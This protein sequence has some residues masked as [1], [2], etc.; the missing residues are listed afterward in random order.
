MPDPAQDLGALLL[1]VG[2]LEGRVGEIAH[3]QNDMRMK[4]DGIAEKLFTAPTREDYDKLGGKMDE[5]LVR[6]DA[7]EAAKDREDGAKGLIARV[8]GSKAFG[9]VVTALLSVIAALIALKEGV[10]K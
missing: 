9:V 3:G 5:A 2:R 1:A 7:L 10:V 8:T 4:V 6:I